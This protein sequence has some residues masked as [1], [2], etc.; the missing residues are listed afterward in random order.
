MKSSPPYRICVVSEDLAAPWDEGIKKFTFSVAQAFKA[1]HE[2]LIVNVDRSD[3][4]ATDGIAQVRSS[5]T[6]VKSELRRTVTAFKPDWILYVP[7]PSNTVSSNM[8]AWVLSLYARVPVVMVGLIPREHSGWRA[9]V[10]K[11]LAPAMTLVPSYR[12]LLR[13]TRMGVSGD[14]LPVGVDTDEFQPASDTERAALRDKL[15]IARDAYVYLHVGHTRPRR[16]IIAL[17]ALAG[18]PGTEIISIGSTSTPETPEI[19]SRLDAAGVRVIRE[20]VRVRDYYHAADC[21]I[22]PVQDHE[23][24]I[25]MPLSVLEALACGTPV[26]TTPFGG[27]PDFFYE[28]DDLLYW[29]SRSDLADAADKMRAQPPRATRSMD[30]FSWQRIAERIVEKVQSL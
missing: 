15:G 1:Q 23:G 27:L 18:R 19:R 7:S 8:R 14:V 24:A 26:L 17:T 21:Y 5:R 30:D 22:F 28:G 25:E 4:G 12:S 9:A 20:F 2:V 10:V 13:L 6:F 29:S 11:G 16:N 3:V